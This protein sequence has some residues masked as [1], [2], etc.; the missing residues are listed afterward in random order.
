M[1]D[2]HKKL[3]SDET[4][5]KKEHNDDVK[6]SKINEIQINDRLIKENHK[7]IVFKQLEMFT[8]KKSHLPF[9]NDLPFDLWIEARKKK[10]SKSRIGN[11]SILWPIKSTSFSLSLRPLPSEARKNCA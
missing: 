5:F 7:K 9:K 8:P 6:M 4:H 1:F 3:D 10:P 11:K 2:L